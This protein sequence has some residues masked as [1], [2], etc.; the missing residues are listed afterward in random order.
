MRA[1]LVSSIVAALVAALSFV[2]LGNF[3]AP[4]QASTLPP[5]Q[6]SWIEQT[7]LC[8]HLQTAGNTHGVGHCMA[9]RFYAGNVDQHRCM[10]NLVGRESGWRVDAKNRRSSAY[11]IP[12]ALP[13]RKMRNHG[14]DWQTSALVQTS[15]MLDYVRG[16]YG[17]MCG[18]WSA[19]QRK[20][21]Y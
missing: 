20:G 7:D 21:W 19:F 16:R 9:D 14:L 1:K 2:E 8:R 5:A 11:G 6:R 17:S 18:A 15:F 13:G 12:Q 4:A 10:D 3:V